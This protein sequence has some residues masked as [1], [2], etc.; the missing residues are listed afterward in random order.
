MPLTPEPFLASQ[1]QI[2]LL[3][4]LLLCP[5]RSVT[6]LHPPSTQYVLGQVH[7]C[8]LV[9]L[10]FSFSFTLPFG[11]ALQEKEAEM[12]LGHHHQNFFFSKVICI[13]LL[14]VLITLP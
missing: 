3:P 7:R 13:V 8:L 5:G 4:H 14:A 11:G 2:V 12:S 6:I 10:H 9:S 1:R